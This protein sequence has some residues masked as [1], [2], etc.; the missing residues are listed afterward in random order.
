MWYLYLIMWYLLIMWYQFLIMNILS[1]DINI[2][3]IPY[4][5][6]LWFRNFLTIYPEKEDWSDGNSYFGRYS[7]FKLITVLKCG[8]KTIKNC[9]AKLQLM[10]HGRITWCWVLKQL[11]SVNC[12]TPICSIISYHIRPHD[13]EILIQVHMISAVY[14]VI[15]IM[16][17]VITA[18]FALSL[19]AA[20]YCSLSRI[21]S[22]NNSYFI[23]K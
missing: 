8:F 12:F 4:I 3:S 20:W 5:K 7:H 13:H 17:H 9:S 19:Y 18:C 23:S 15:F 10:N 21:I 2:I 16:N 1:C 11:I 22:C 6:L 14:H